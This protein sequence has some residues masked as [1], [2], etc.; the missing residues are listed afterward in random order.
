MSLPSLGLDVS[1][2]KFNACLVRAGG[3]LRRRTFST[4]EAG[5]SQLP[6]WLTKDGAALTHACL[7]SAASRAR[8]PTARMPR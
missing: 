1:K 5:F 3:K 6:V 8:R 7:E 2:L 4:D